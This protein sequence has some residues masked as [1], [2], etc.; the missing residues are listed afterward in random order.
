MKNNPN[1]DSKKDQYRSWASEKTTLPIWH[2]PWWLDA[3]AGKESWNAVT[4]G[5]IGSYLASHPYVISRRFGFKT[6]SRPPL[7]Q[8]L[9]PW[10]SSDESSAPPSLS[11]QNQLLGLLSHELPRLDSYVQNWMPEITNWLPFYWQG[12]RQTTR[13]T[14]QLDLNLGHEKLWANLKGRCRSEIRKAEVTNELRV[15][16]TSKLEDILP[17]TIQTFNA[18]G[19]KLPFQARILENVIQQG[20]I[21]DQTTVYVAR[22]NAGETCGFALIVRDNEKAYYLL[23]GINS[24]DRGSGAMSLLLWQAIKDS[25]NRGLSKFDFEGSMIEPIEGFFRSFGTAQ[26]PYFGVTKDFN[27]ALRIARALFAS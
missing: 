4:V 1:S 8:A 16:E 12:F 15:Y 24:L 5:P 21:F 18:S 3:T 19:L 2:Q 10:F 13:Y 7:T 6:L 27:P 26:V 17:I 14:Y 25:C 23:G 20:I 11:V 22:N 9:G